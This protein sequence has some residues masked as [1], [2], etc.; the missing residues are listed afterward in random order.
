MVTDR[1]KLVHFYKP[2]VDYWEL[3]DRQTDPLELRDVSKLP[4]HAATITELKKE[5]ARLRSEL[6]VP[7]EDAPEASGNT[8]PMPGKQQPGKKN[9]A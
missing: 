8:R 1:F 6:K 5:V 9:A 2:D 4:E 7:A 3:Y